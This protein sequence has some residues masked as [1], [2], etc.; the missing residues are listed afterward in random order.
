M[1]TRQAIC[2][3]G[4]CEKFCGIEVDVVDGRMAKVRFDKTHPITSGVGCIKGLHVVDYQNDP[5]RLI[6]PERK[7][8]KGWER[9]DWD[10]AIKD[11]GQRLRTLADE[12]GP[13]AIAT[14]WGNAADST[15]ILLANSLCHA[16]GSPNS[17]NV[18]SLEYT[19]RGAV[20]D[21]V[22][23]NEHYILQPDAGHAAFALLLG[24]NPYATKGMTLLQRRPHVEK[25]L[26]SI[27]AR[28]GMLV[29]VDP[30]LTETA[31]VASEHVAIRPGTDLILLLAMIRRILRTGAYDRDFVAAHCLGL[32]EWRDVIEGLDLDAAIA[33]TGIARAR[34]E[35]LADAFAAADGAFATSRVGVQTSFNTSLTEW[36]IMTLNAITGNI[37]RPGGVYFNPGIIDMP[38]FIKRFA[39]RQN[40]APSRIGG[41]PH[42]FAG[43]P[44]SV[45]ADDV[46][47]DDPQRIR[48]LVV[49]AGNPVISFPNTA[50]MEKALERLDLL[51]SIDL[52]RSDTGAFADYNLP[53]ATIYEKGGLHFMTTNFEPF[54]FA[55]W[56]PKLVAPRGEARSEWDIVKALSRAAGVPFLN[57]PAAD[58]VARLLDMLGIGFS[59]D[60]LYRHVLPKGLGL[61]RLKRAPRG[62]KL[63]DIEWGRF[64][65][66]GLATPS[67]KIEL[68]PR[69]FIAALPA[70]LARLRQDDADFPL[71]LI[72]GARRLETFNSW[73]HNIPALMDKVKGN[74]ATM[75]VDDAA[76]LG[77]KEGDRIRVTSKTGKIEIEARLS[78]DIKEGVIA[79]HQFWGHV[80]DSGMRTSRR[81]PGVNVNHLHDDR[82]RDAFTA[83]PV[84]N[85]TA[86]RVE[87]LGPAAPA[88][89]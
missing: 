11:I 65:E 3:I 72:S 58:K 71:R 8:A 88:S 73:T 40:R 76:R 85:G 44:A 45:F 53:A 20:A 52:Y 6:Y 15:G 2:K 35:R 89:A 7:T 17:F 22:L 37:D 18:L 86:C 55:E 24:T 27:R 41:Y 51:V 47:S 21:R 30:R 42:I 69:D 62:V 32:S 34:I 50:K 60:M 43:P 75:N 12:H 78:P 68:A 66:K 25:E 54:P 36:A 80:Y 23:G 1:T 29:V 63:G 39:H 81:Y 28:G 19:D 84:F 59:E 87:R 74:W 38:A 48:A 16:F 64:L 56:R 49:I 70:A 46:L 10:R 61:K 4:A 57:E 26:R 9:V 33:L 67:G 31:R 5:D 79:I 13:N 83:M 77:I 82:E 14:Y